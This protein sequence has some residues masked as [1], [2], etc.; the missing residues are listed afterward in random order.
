[1]KR[2][3]IESCAICGERRECTRDHI[4]PKS[5][6]LPPRPD[7]LVTVPACKDCNNGS[8]KD[9]D[10]FKMYLALHVAMHTKKG[11]KFFKT[12]LRTFRHNTR[13]RSRIFQTLKPRDFKTPG[14]VFLGSGATVLWD[15]EIHNKIIEK[16][17]RGLYHHHYG[18]ILGNKADIYVYWHRSF[19]QHLNQYIVNTNWMGE[20]EFLYIHTDVEDSPLSSIWIFQ[21]YNSHWASGITI[22]KVDD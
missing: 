6:F 4:P 3:I 19:P 17:V 9:D 5:I 18:K 11:E 2:D 20:G 10:S 7:N 8:S 16:T 21:F 22:E 13:L 14:G 12:A 1:M 15:S